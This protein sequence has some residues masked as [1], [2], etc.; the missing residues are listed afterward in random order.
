MDNQELI[1]VNSE[2]DRINTRV[3]NIE[4]IAATIEDLAEKGVEAFVKHMDHK[5]ETQQKELE[6]DN[7]KHQREL[8]LENTIHK[9]SVI[10]VG[11]TVVGVVALVFTAMILGEKELVKTIL[12]SSLAIG[13]GIGIKSALNKKGS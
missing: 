4:R 1:E 8:E 5:E 11:A 3:E 12:T 9:R 2:I 6:L 7:A 10:I 13:A